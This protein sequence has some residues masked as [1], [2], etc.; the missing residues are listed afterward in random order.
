MVAKVSMRLGE[1]LALRSD[2]DGTRMTVSGRLVEAGRLSSGHEDLDA[3]AGIVI[4]VGDRKLTLTGL[5][6]L[7][8]AAFRQQVGRPIQFTIEAL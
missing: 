3:P 1:I 4:A 6:S 8:L 2:A 5:S 7:E